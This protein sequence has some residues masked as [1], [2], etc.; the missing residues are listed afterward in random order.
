[1]SRMGRNA[2]R[3]P[4]M[5]MPETSGSRWFDLEP[6][7]GHDRVAVILKMMGKAEAGGAGAHHQH[8]APG[9]RARHGVRQVEG[10]PPG[11]QA[12]DLEPPGQGQNVFQRTGLDLRN[13]DRFLFL[14]DAG[15]HAIVAD[16]MTRGGGERVV[17]H[18]D[19]EGGKTVSAGLQQVHFADLLVERTSRQGDAMGRGAEG[20]AL[21]L[22][23]TLRAAVLA[24]VVTEDAVV[25][26]R[27]R[28]CE[29]H[30]LVGQRE[31]FPGTQVHGRGGQHGDAVPDLGDHRHQAV[32]IRSLG[33]AEEGTLA[34]PQH[35]GTRTCGPCRESFR[36]G[37]LFPVARFVLEPVENGPRE[38]KL[39][40]VPADQG[41]DV[42]REGLAI[43]GIDVFFEPDACGA[44]AHEDKLALI[45]RIKVPARRAL[46]V[47][48]AG[49]PEE[50]A[51]EF[52]HKGAKVDEELGVFLL[53]EVPGCCPGAHQPVEERHVVALQRLAEGVVEAHEPVT[54]VEVAKGK[55]VGEGK[56]VHLG[57]AD[58]STVTM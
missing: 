52:L 23:Q 54:T 15:L 34:I 12:V 58:R 51:D 53:G 45:D 10:I 2:L 20:R 32:G 21:L 19:R 56:F 16:A 38:G 1:M 5:S 14:I 17:D 6:V 46:A 47:K 33:Q 4:K 39:V 43:D 25:G 8:A 49:H 9:R 18:D 57:P 11:Q 26:V 44:P 42:T 55:P 50:F 28:L 41:L 35:S 7:D 31:T 3:L 30:S 36:T 37:D 13:V 40:E 22:Q 27:H 29:I 48:F 24:L